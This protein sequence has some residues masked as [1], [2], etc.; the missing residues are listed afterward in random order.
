MIDMD[1]KVGPWRLR[2]WGLIVNLVGNVLA[3]VGMVRLIREDSV[4]L[5]ILGT[6]ITVVCVALLAIPARGDDGSS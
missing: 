6:A 3:L 5:L 2:L 4:G 1:R